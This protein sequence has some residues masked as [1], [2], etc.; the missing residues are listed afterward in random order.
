MIGVLELA[1][2]GVSCSNPTLHRPN[3]GNHLNKH[4]MVPTGW[5]GQS[6]PE[7]LIWLCPN[8][9]ELE[10][11]ILNLYVRYDGPP[12]FAELRP[13]PLYLRALAK[14]AIEANGGVIPHV[15]T[16]A[17]RQQWIAREAYEALSTR[18]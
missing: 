5:G 13:Y 10:H 15:Y 3:P 12:P 14:R 17:Y 6:V 9:H 16:G 2:I 7:N 8:C 18:R 11:S 1:P 4:H